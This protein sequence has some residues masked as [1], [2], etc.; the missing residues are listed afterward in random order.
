MF[1]IIPKELLS[2]MDMNNAIAITKEEFYKKYERTLKI[3]G[4]LK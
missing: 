1:K 3:L 2:S 4:D